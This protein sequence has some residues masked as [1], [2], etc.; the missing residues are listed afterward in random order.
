MYKHFIS[1]IL[2]CWAMLGFVQVTEGIWENI[3]WLS[4]LILYSSIIPISVWVT[5]IVITKGGK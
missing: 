4:V 1:M 2:A 5:C 3:D